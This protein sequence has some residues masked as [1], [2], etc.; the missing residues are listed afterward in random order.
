MLFETNFTGSYSF[1]R[2]AS[3]EENVAFSVLCFIPTNDAH[4]HFKEVFNVTSEFH[5]SHRC[6]RTRVFQNFLKD[7]IGFE[8]HILYCVYATM[9][10]IA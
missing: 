8:L 5:T 10:V 3:T 1:Q 9:C 4:Q 6:H 7:C 2:I